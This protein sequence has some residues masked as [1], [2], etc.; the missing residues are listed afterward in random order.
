MRRLGL[1]Y[2]V[3]DASRLQPFSQEETTEAARLCRDR[4]GQSSW[5]WKDPRSTLFLGDWDG[6]LPDGRYVFVY[7][8]PLE[9][10][11]SL[12]RR[13]TDLD[14][15]RDLWLG[16]RV[17]ELYN[18]ALL[19]F[20]RR[21][22]ERCLLCNVAGLTV[23]Q[24]SFSREINA[25]LGLSLADSMSDTVYDASE[26]TRLSLG[27]ESQLVLEALAPSIAGLYSELEQAADIPGGPLRSDDATG[28]RTLRTFIEMGS[29]AGLAAA[30][31]DATLRLLL[32]VL[33][34]RAVQHAHN[35][36]VRYISQLESRGRVGRKA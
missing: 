32:T 27:R 13:G 4:E 22:H 34:A 26:M 14:C 7:R 21:K 31:A 12:L 17:W 23:R 9:V 25:R 20:Y 18:R 28:T 1:T 11:L 8:H 5:G 6:M 24:A 3:A 15:V 16:L 30:C 33:D 2:L 19:A 29:R 36:L 35:Q 10:T